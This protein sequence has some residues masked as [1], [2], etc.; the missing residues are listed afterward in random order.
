MGEGLGLRDGKKVGLF[1]GFSV[2]GMK[3]GFFVV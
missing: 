3:V 1:V 2:V